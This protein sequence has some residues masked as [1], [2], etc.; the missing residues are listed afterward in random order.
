MR[1]LS[2]RANR[3]LFAPGGLTGS[4]PPVRLPP[5]PCAGLAT[6]LLLAATL[7]AQTPPVA[8][9]PAI[10]LDPFV[11]TPSHFDL[12]DPAAGSA[13]LTHRDLQ[14]LP[15]VG[16]DLFRSIAR[17]PGVAADD[18]TARFR[19]R[20]APHRQLL[21]R[22]DGADLLEPFHLKDV[23]GA[24]SIIDLH[25]IRRLDLTTGGFT[26]DYGN[27]AAGVLTME[28]ISPEGP[29]PQA[30]AGISLTSM[31][32]GAGGGFAAGQGR[33]A[34]SL[35][36]GYPDI[37]LRVEGRADE[38]FPRYWDA[39][40]KAEY[41]LSARHRVSVHTLLS[42]DTLRVLDAD[43]PELR[44]GYDTSVLWGRW[45]AAFTDRLAA[46]TVA[47]ASWLTWRRDG[48]GLYGNRYRLELR[49]RR[50]LEWLDLRQDWSYAA[51]DRLALRG[52]WQLGTG[53]AEYAYRLYRE[54][55]VVS[56]GVLTGRPR[57]VQHALRPDGNAQ[58]AFAAAR[59]TVTP[60]LT[61]EPGVRL[62]RHSAP[63]D[64][65]ASPRLNAALSLGPR[66]ALRAAW[67]AY[68]QSQGLHELPVAFDD[69]TFRRAERAEH[70]ILGLQ[71]QFAG[72]LQAR[73]EAYQRLTRRP[74]P[75]WINRF[76]TY[77]VFPEA[78]T[79]RLL[80]TPDRAEAHGVEFLLQGRN[81][82]RFDWTLSYAWSRAEETTG[83]VV[84]P[85]LRDQRHA[86]YGD[87]TY[88]PTPRWSFSAAWQYH[89]GWPVTAVN[90]SLAPLNNGA[91]VIVRSFGPTLGERLEAYHRL[92]LRAAHTLPLRRGVLRVF[93]DV[94]NAYDRGNAIAYDYDTSVSGG[95]LVVRRKPRNMLPFIPSAGVSWEI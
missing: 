95:N 6:S 8:P 27:R 82:P 85:G 2:A 38:I 40:A 67:G 33:W 46:E 18:F 5:L 84:L 50:S 52:G 47:T 60:A 83:T 79:D 22:L 90:Y 43:G 61:L 13:T 4:H 71:H 48:A 12:A 15:Q 73:V 69:P 74:R 20:G 91:R 56:G 62:D 54:E 7:P 63:G 88:R 57:T 53:S 81:R 9:G 16:E 42:R 75:H 59:L 76:D 28:T 31:R 86:F 14:T 19:V 70:R 92:D 23:D 64:E 72:G 94:F 17:L 10:R 41:D 89:T 77:N 21:V 1:A 93:V 55:P 78:Q 44:S 29:R 51:G 66:T 49:D 45:R 87:L 3:N 25:L 58:G 26:T 24:L 36:R 37:A 68:A 11:V 39:Y 65:E 80:L 30:G 34:A 35:R 32:A